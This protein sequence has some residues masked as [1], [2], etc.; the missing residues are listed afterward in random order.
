[1]QAAVCE[2][3]PKNKCSVCN[4]PHVVNYIERFLYDNY[5]VHMVYNNNVRYFISIISANIPAR[6]IT[7]SYVLSAFNDSVTV[8]ERYSTTLPIYFPG[9]LLQ[10]KV[11]GPTISSCNTVELSSN[12]DT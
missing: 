12:Q 10:P 6:D 1:M 4:T 7:F 11:C 2:Y 3:G 8:T 9:S 5:Y